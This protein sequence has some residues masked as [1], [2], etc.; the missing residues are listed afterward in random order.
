MSEMTL[1]VVL[2]ELRSLNQPV[3]KP[4]RLPTDVDVDHAQAFLGVVF[5]PDYRKYLL[6]ASDVVHGVME[7]CT[8]VGGGHTNLASVAA[9]AWSVGVPR[10]LLP[11]CEDNGDYY[12]MNAAGEVV[13]WSHEGATDERWSD[14]A[15][16]IK[17]VWID[18]G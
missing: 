14:L 4:R 2:R 10:D 8:I 6:A 16:W 17:R 18:G 9:D 7:P 5:H 11:I 3:P 15:S 1:D 13:F 12:C